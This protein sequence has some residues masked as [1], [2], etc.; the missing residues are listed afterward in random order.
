MRTTTSHTDRPAA[1]CEPSVVRSIT[2]TR[3]TPRIVSV[4]NISPLY[5]G[6]Q[7]PPR[8]LHAQEERQGDLPGCASN[9]RFNSVDVDG[10]GNV[11][12]DLRWFTLRRTFNL[13]ARSRAQARTICAKLLPR[14]TSRNVSGEL[15]NFEGLLSVWRLNGSLGDGAFS[16]TYG[17]F[18]TTSLLAIPTKVLR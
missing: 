18:L 14:F 1:S 7:D 16:K 6:G 8:T 11:T 9:V 15:K 12:P 17:D 5:T 3:V 4:S 2:C 13:P 10:D